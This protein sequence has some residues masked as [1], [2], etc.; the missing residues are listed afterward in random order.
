MRLGIFAKIFVRPTVA[1]TLD[2]VASRGLDCVQ[3]NFSCAGLPSM[4]DKIDPALATQIGRE[5]R[6]RNL[7]IAAVSGTFNMIDPDL[8]RRQA[9]LRRLE[10]MAASCAGLG[11]SLITL[12]TGTRD[13]EDMW[14]HHP[15]NES[16]E[17][18]RDLIESMTVAL[19]I[20]GKYNIFLGVE[21]ETA[22]GV[23][24]ARAARRLLDEMRSPRLKIVID[25]ANL[26]HPGESGKVRDI[27]TEAFDLLGPDL[28]LAHAKDFRDGGKME[29]VAPGKGILP[30][31]HYLQLL[32]ASKFEGPLIMHSLAEAEV[33]ESAAFLRGKMS[34]VHDGIAFNYRE[35]G[36]GLPFFFQHGLGGDLNQTFGLFRPPP[37]V[38]MISFDC[39]AHG[40]THPVGPEEKINFASF[41]DD[42]LALMD[43]LQI[44][45]AVVGGVSMGAGVALNFT[46][47]YPARALGLIL[48]RPAWLD[49]PRRDN[50]EVY[51]TIT[52]LIRRHG[53]AKGLE[54]FERSPLYQAIFAQS[55]STARS[56]AW[57]FQAPRAE[58]TVA[59]LER[60]PLDSPNHERAE[61][62]AIR[63]PTLVMANR[64]DQ[65]HPFEYGETLAREI[66]GAEFKEVTSKSVSP[67][68]H[69]AGIQQFIESFLRQHFLNK[70]NPVL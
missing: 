19:E 15:Q 9:G 55:P 10:E 38:R 31:D 26:F 29:Y 35:T 21:P 66:P 34:F 7:E 70:A 48:H 5:A 3:F 27:L 63:V 54:V 59:K 18:W 4:P 65:V 69:L 58:E 28:A 57:Q 17:A 1:A 39:R 30:W 49:G 56:L 50:V 41:A 60:I 53:A 6:R 8:T 45:Q 51:A 62:K 42:L 64:Q 13:S 11:T 61:W 32:R 46:L 22:N 37:E 12:C 40:R 24:S 47:R 2:A 14:R 20:A 33:D 44:R 43:Y 25:A 52:Q 23:S 16:P 67:E 68:R 36:R